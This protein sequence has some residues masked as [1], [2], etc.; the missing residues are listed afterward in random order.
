M[1]KNNYLNFFIIKILILLT[2]NKLFA[3]IIILISCDN[4][5]DEFLKNKYVLDLEKS[6]M[7]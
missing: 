1:R 3:E 5:K 6:I 4:Q 2:S 7:T